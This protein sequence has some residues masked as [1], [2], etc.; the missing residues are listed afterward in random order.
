MHAHK[1]RLRAHTCASAPRSALAS[2]AH[3]PGRPRVGSTSA[4]S[5]RS[6]L[7]EWILVAAA[8]ADVQL[9]VQRGAAVERAGELVGGAVVVGP[10]HESELCAREAA[11]A[12]R[13]RIRFT[14]SKLSGCAQCAHNRR[15]HVG[16]HASGARDVRRDAVHDGPAPGAVAHRPRAPRRPHRRHASSS[17]VGG[18]CRHRRG[19]LRN[20]PPCV[21]N[22]HPR[23]TPRCCG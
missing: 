23:S 10:V 21:L 18:G 7:S 15:L 19:P 2:L 4:S 9:E 17:S 3:P 6:T 16:E 1:A 12:R 11:R 5:V 22:S 13:A 14:C 8:E 20:F